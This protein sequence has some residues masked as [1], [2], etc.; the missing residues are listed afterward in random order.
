[1]NDKWECF[2]CCKEEDFEILP[3]GYLSNSHPL[4]NTCADSVLTNEN[5]KQRYRLTYHNRMGAIVIA[6]NVPIQTGYVIR[7]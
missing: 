5:H 1:M 2:L 6:L 7:N 3:Q 4:C